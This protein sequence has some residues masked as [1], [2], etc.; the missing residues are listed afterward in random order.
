M[1]QLINDVKKTI[2]SHGKA[3]STC[4]VTK[5]TFIPGKMISMQLTSN[6]KN[7]HGEKSTEEVPPCVIPTSWAVL[8]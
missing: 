5:I 4:W 1:F 8:K 7:H 2:H 6:F 3:N